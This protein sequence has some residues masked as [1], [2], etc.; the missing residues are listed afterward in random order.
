MG[1]ILL[2]QGEILGLVAL[3]FHQV[4]STFGIE[5]VITGGL[6]SG[7]YCTWIFSG[8]Q[9]FRVGLCH[10]LWY[11]KVVV[12]VRVLRLITLSCHWVMSTPRIEGLITSSLNSGWNCTWSIPGLQVFIVVLCHELGQC[13]SVAKV[14]GMDDDDTFIFIDMSVLK[15][16]IVRWGI[17]L[18]IE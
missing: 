7:W 16:E 12:R 17:N 1:T 15:V 18:L 14:G 6:E 2:H 8:I 13:K 10:E 3:G 11:C 4:M 5:G 9:V